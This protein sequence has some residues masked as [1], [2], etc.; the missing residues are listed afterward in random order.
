MHIV[1]RKACPL[2]A[3]S[4]MYTSRE[5]F[6]SYNTGR[7]RAGGDHLACSGTGVC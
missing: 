4:R 3:R 2:A 6:I 1:E 5:K 7:M